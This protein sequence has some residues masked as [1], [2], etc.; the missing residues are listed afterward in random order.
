MQGQLS[1]GEHLL[2]SHLALDVKL[3]MQKL[4]VDKSQPAA[5]EGLTCTDVQQT[6]LPQLQLLDLKLHRLSLRL[7]FL[8]WESQQKEDSFMSTQI[9]TNL[10]ESSSYIQ[11][12]TV[13]C[14]LKWESH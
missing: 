13:G 12:N 6:L 3:T 5:K 11:T 4:E 7:D 2:S 1:E 14:T 9:Q 10:L 8:E